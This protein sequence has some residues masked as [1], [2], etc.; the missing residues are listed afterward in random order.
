VSE[1]EQLLRR[2]VRE[3]IEAHEA[4]RAAGDTSPATHDDVAQIAAELATGARRR[5]G[6]G[7]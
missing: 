2:I 1:L 4:R 5:R 6:G 3:E 7:S